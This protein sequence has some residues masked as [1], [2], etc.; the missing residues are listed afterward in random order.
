[1]IILLVSFLFIQIIR[2]EE[3]LSG[4][5][6]PEKVLQWTDGQQLSEKRLRFDDSNSLSPFGVNILNL[7]PTMEPTLNSVH[8][9]TIL[10]S[11]RP[12][13][14][15]SH[16]P[17]LFPT[18]PPSLAPST[19]SEPSPQPSFEPT[20]VPTIASTTLTPSSEPSYQNRPIIR[21]ECNITLFNISSSTLGSSE[22]DA[23][24]KATALMLK[25]PFDRIS[26]ARWHLVTSTSSR[27]RLVS[28]V[29]IEQPQTTYLVAPETLW[30]VEKEAESV[31]NTAVSPDTSDTRTQIKASGEYNMQKYSSRSNIQTD[32][33]VFY[34]SSVD[35]RSPALPAGDSTESSLSPSSEFFDAVPRMLQD[36][37]LETVPEGKLRSRGPYMSWLSSSIYSQL[38]SLSGICGSQAKYATTVQNTLELGR[39]E[40]LQSGTIYY[41]YF[42]AASVEVMMVDFPEYRSIT[43]GT[44]LMNF[45]RQRVRS[46]LRTGNFS[47]NIQRMWQRQGYTG[48]SS[49]SGVTANRVVLRN[50]GLIFAPSFSPTAAPISIKENAAVATSVASF[51]VGAGL[52]CLIIGILAVICAA[53]RAEFQQPPKSVELTSLLSEEGKDAFGD[54][55]E[56]IVEAK[57][58][59]KAKSGS[60]IAGMEEDEENAKISSAVKKK[61]HH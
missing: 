18:E 49:L 34:D 16:S 52:G 28:K 26:T 45:L 50:Q 27:R 4:G 40:Y 54:R 29:D 38:C 57:S 36:R 13:T 10:P 59:N 23:I 31:S 20:A 1:M 43:N 8:V 56:D 44:R 60:K 19:S 5:F 58:R 46:N 33:G 9:P 3:Q 24:N 51:V 35:S 61:P 48:T 11:S 37:D 53:R 41:D 6:L 30:D 2:C 7:E 14:Y 42:Y 22:M 39:S 12:S 21:V 17:S 15:L 32:L 25:V 55:I 47:A